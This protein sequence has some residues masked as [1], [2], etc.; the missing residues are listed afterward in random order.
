MQ[1]F[2]RNHVAEQIFHYMD[3]NTEMNLTTTDAAN[4]IIDIRSLKKLLDLVVTCIRY[5]LLLM[6]L[7]FQMQAVEET[8][9][10]ST[11]ERSFG[12]LAMREI[13]TM[14]QD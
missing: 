8:E 4:D 3:K 7:E 12:C 9:T 10:F 6:L 5:S 2:E 13:N 11:E 1:C 14:V